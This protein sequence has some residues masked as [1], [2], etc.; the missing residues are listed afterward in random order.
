[1]TTR[2]RVLLRAHLTASTHLAVAVCRTSDRF[3]DAGQTAPHGV[4]APVKLRSKCIHDRDEN[5]MRVEQSVAAKHGEKNVH[6]E[7]QHFERVLFVERGNE[8]E[9]LDFDDVTCNRVATTEQTNQMQSS[10]NHRERFGVRTQ[11]GTLRK[12]QLSSCYEYEDEVLVTARCGAKHGQQQ[13]RYQ[14]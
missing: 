1:M 11:N 2:Q 12:T 7:R 14:R 10:S 8:R 13:S 4:A 3:T 5:K 6:T 9:G